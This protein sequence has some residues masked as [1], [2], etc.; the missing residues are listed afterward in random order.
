MEETTG[1]RL[2]RS[3]CAQDEEG[4]P[5]TAVPLSAYPLT[6]LPTYPPTAYPLTRLPAYPL[7]GP[8][9]ATAG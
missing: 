3:R 7:T 8:S 1:K 5:L 6:H 2:S 4:Y 9:P